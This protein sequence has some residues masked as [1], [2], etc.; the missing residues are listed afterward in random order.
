[1]FVLLNEAS[2]ELFVLGVY[3]DNLQI[4]HSAQLDDHGRAP[5]GSFYREFMD[6]LEAAWDV[7]DEG[8]MDDLLGIEVLRNPDGTITLHQKAYIEKMVRRFL[9]DGLSSRM[10]STS[11]PYAK[12][13]RSPCPLLIEL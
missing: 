8:P 6:E 13:W 4:A 3:V 10:Q 9:P 7:V 5:E 11:L 1:M 2:G 12:G